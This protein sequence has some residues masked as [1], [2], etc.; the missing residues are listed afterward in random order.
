MTKITTKN[1]NKILEAAHSPPHPHQPPSP[2]AKSE[3]IL[4]VF[5]KKSRAA[6]GERRHEYGKDFSTLG[7][8][9]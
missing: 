7:S 2:E 3:N 5:F 1:V 9:L 6:T 8:V 4:V